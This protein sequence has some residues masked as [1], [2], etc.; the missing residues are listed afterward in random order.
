M[1]PH[2]DAVV[3]G[4]PE[5]DRY[6][7]V[8]TSSRL[9]RRAAPAPRAPKCGRPATS[10]AG[11][12]IRCLEIPG[13]PLQA[14]LVGFPHPEE[15]VGA[16]MLR[17]S[18]AAARRGARRGARFRLLGGHGRRP[19]R[20][21][22]STSRGST[23]PAT[24]PTSSCA[25]TA[26]RSPISSSG[27][28]RSSTSATASCARCPRRARSWRSSTAARSTSTWVC[29]TPRSAAATSTSRP[30]T[31]S[32]EADLTAILE[33]AGLPPHCGEPEVPYL[34]TLVRRH[35]PGL[36]PRRR[37]RLL[38]KLR[39]RSRRAPQLGHVERRLRRG[40]VG[41]LHAGRRS[42]ALHDVADR[43]P[44]PCRA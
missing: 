23:G 35:L 5:Y 30:P 44:A 29:T 4:V 7:D 39:R 13:G 20:P 43:R 40:R 34:R 18:A 9:R 42:A 28:S 25:S 33:A 6:P 32:C 41:L 14:T 27:P 16:L 3:A 2:F 17:V 8:W 38:R 22:C 19:R 12:P 15:P 36:L 37:L 11:R 26:R 24:S 1:F 21:A 31:R 10:R